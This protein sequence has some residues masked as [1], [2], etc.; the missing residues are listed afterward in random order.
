MPANTIV[1][2]FFMEE[3]EEQSEQ[4]ETG[5]PQQETGLPQQEVKGML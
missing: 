4:S 1:P 5:L 3:Y 2:G